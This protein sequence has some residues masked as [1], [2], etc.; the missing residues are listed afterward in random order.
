MEPQL[1]ERSGTQLQPRCSSNCSRKDLPIHYGKGLQSEGSPFHLGML[2]APLNFTGASCLSYPWLGTWAA[3]DPKKGR[4]RSQESKF[5]SSGSNATSSHR[6]SV[7]KPRLAPKL[8]MLPAVPFPSLSKVSATKMPLAWEELEPV[9]KKNSLE[10]VT[11]W[12]VG[13][14]AC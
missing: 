14:K 8:Q 13:A 6:H 12:V 11:H 5:T 3:R 10:P 1:Q 4:T 9:R 2:P 7:P